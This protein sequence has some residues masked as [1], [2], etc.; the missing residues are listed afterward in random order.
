MVL[1]TLH[2]QNPLRHWAKSVTG[3]IFNPGSVYNPSINLR[4]TMNT[5]TILSRLDHL[6]VHHTFNRSKLLSLPR[7]DIKLAVSTDRHGVY[8]DLAFEARP[9]SWFRLGDALDHPLAAEAKRH[10]GV[11]CCST[12]SDLDSVEQMDAWISR[13]LAA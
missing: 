8:L 4:N 5:A 2:H 6:P 3:Y 9:G 10:Y 13:V 7:P 12:R 11:K 1:I